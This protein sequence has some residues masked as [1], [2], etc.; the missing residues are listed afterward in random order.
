MTVLKVIDQL[1]KLVVGKD[2]SYKSACPNIV[3]TI[4]K[5]IPPK[6]ERNFFH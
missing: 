4:E 6:S 1:E 2:M 3:K 5:V